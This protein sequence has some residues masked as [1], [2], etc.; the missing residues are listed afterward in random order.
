MAGNERLLRERFRKVVI[1]ELGHAFGLIHCHVPICV[2]RPGTYVEDIDQ[3]K[4][5]FCNKCYAELEAALEN[6]IEE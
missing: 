4:H 1:H 6:I 2:M 3:K 5:Q